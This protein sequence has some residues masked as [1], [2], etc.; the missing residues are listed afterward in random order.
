M[1]HSRCQRSS[2]PPWLQPARHRPGCPAQY[3]CLLQVLGFFLSSFSDVPSRQ[4]T[5]QRR[6]AGA[7]AS[8]ECEFVGRGG[9]GAAASPLAHGARPPARPFP[10]PACAH[11]VPVCSL[12]C[13]H[14][15]CTALSPLLAARCSRAT[16]SPHWSQP[17]PVRRSAQPGAPPAPMSRHVAIPNVPHQMPAALRIRHICPPFPFFTA[18]DDFLPSSARG[19]AAA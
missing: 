4:H 6:G 2:S 8:R 15:L 13:S 19:C 14:F 17:C 12:V 3:G 1:R 10:A 7:H 16:L 9:P 5:P 11:R 18:P